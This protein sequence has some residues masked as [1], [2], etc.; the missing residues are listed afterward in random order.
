MIPE[1]KLESYWQDIRQV[2]GMSEDARPE[3]LRF[4]ETRRFVNS[5]SSLSEDKYFLLMHALVQLFPSLPYQL[6]CIPDR[7]RATDGH[8]ISGLPSIRDRISFLMTQTMERVADNSFMRLGPLVKRD[9]MCGS[10]MDFTAGQVL[11]VLYHKTLVV[12]WIRNRVNA[13]QPVFLDH[14]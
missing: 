12:T 5:F 9:E 14:V 4:L 2:L 1:D 3:E 8:T 10:W 7:Q 11:D 13:G 6:F